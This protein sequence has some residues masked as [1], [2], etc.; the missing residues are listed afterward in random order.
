MEKFLAID[1]LR[2]EGMTL[3]EKYSNKLDSDHS[4]T[5]LQLLESE[6]NLNIESD[7]FGSDVSY[8]LNLIIEILTSYE[9]DMI[10]ND[11]LIFDDICIKSINIDDLSKYTLG[12][13]IIYNNLPYM[14]IDIDYSDVSMLLGSNFEGEFW[15]EI[16]ELNN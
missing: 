11:R 13:L 15:I 14:I 1:Y 12:D 9:D 5:F 6:K 7:T 8:Y 3:L 10:K 16:G 2:E 4:E